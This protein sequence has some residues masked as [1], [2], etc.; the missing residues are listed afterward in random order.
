MGFALS[1]ITLTSIAFKPLG[2]IPQCHTGEGEDYS[3]QL[4][5]SNAP[6]NSESF[7]LVC[8][9]PDAPLLT[10]QSYGFV[11][12]VLYGIPRPVRE[13]PGRL[14]GVCSRKKP[15]WQYWIWW[16]YAPA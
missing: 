15:L 11:H 12:W 2:R 10:P 5:W 6:E 1:D 8:H 9:D 14:R 16:A 13:L 4:S 3:P 7:A